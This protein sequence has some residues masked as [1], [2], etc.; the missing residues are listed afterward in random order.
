MESNPSEDAELGVISDLGELRCRSISWW[1]VK[2]E[3]QLVLLQLLPLLV[4][5][6]LAV[7]ELLWVLPL[8]LRLKE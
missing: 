7:L 5:V 6:L 4:E 3:E 8:L 1:V 2:T